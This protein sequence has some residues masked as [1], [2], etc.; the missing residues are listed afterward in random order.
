MMERDGCVGCKYEHEDS[1]SKYC[2]NCK[3]NAIDKYQRMTNAD[4]IRNM[5]DE[6]LAEDRIKTIYIESIPVYV[7]FANNL[8][9]TLESAIKYELDWL[10]SES[11]E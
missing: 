11:E 4:R 9:S 10:Q 1:D 7:G 6:E 3:Q 5:S 2:V 8:F